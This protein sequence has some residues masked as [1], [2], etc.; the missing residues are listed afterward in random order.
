MFW[1]KKTEF[2]TLKKRSRENFQIINKFLIEEINMIWEEI[3]KQKREIA[4]WETTTK[5][6]MQT[7]LKNWEIKAATINK[8]LNNAIQKRKQQLKEEQNETICN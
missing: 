4:N 2:E 5:E 3:D 8:T 6:A 7:I 1:A